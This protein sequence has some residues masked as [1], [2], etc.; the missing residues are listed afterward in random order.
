MW[1]E[2][3][4]TKVPQEDYKVPIKVKLLFKQS[5]SLIRS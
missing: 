2:L 1:P 5:N 4:E 3:E